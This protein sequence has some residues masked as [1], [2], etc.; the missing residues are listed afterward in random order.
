[1]ATDEFSADAEPEQSKWQQEIR[2]MNSDGS[3]VRIAND[4]WI[5]FLNEKTKGTLQP[6][7]CGKWMHFF[8]SEN[9]DYVDQVVAGA[10]LSGAVA[11]AKYT[12]PLILETFGQPSG[13]CCFYLND[14][15]NQGH[16]RILSY[17][18]EHDLIRKTK[19]G[20]LYNISFKYDSQTYAREYKS[21]GFS[22]KIHL[23]D[24]ADL[25]TGL[26]LRS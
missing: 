4:D 26:F 21:T 9:R 19:S 23:A 25:E 20:K 13:V 18:M 1:M 12:G 15:D 6:E 24:F 10:V 22:G 5:W 14:N 11:V 2:P 16:I 7:H 17:M 8:S 3:I